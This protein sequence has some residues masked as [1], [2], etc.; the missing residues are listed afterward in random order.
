MSPRLTDIYSFRITSI[1]AQLS[2]ARTALKL[3]IA[4]AASLTFEPIH[5]GLS[6]AVLHQAFAWPA[7][8]HVGIQVPATSWTPMGIDHFRLAVGF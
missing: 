2:A 6:R 4:E 8:R 1:R 3:Q 7:G 5:P